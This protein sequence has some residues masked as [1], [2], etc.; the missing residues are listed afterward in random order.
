MQQ[1]ID[2]ST[3]T[4]FPEPDSVLWTH[5]ILG[6]VA[7]L[8]ERALQYIY[9]SKSKMKPAE[10]YESIDKDLEQTILNLVQYNRDYT[11]PMCHPILMSI[12]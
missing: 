6:H 2:E 10:D 4:E 7:I 12:R 1:R 3:A 5:C 8:A 9:C 11:T